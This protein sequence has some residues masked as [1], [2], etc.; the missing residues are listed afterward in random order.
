MHDIQA[1]HFASYSFNVGIAF[2]F[3]VDLKHVYQMSYLIPLYGRLIYSYTHILR[4]IPV[5]ALVDTY[6]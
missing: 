2:V 5:A 3:Y 1:I 4:R 6:S